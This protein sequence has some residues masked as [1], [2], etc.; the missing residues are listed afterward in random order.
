MKGWKLILAI[1]S[2]VI[3]LGLIYGSLYL[4]KYEHAKHIYNKNLATFNLCEDPSSSYYDVAS[5]STNVGDGIPFVPQC[6]N[7]GS[8]A[9][10]FLGFPYYKA[11]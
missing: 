5:R 8:V 11:P 6:V 3:V 7:P 9:H 2:P 1:W 10:G 4:V